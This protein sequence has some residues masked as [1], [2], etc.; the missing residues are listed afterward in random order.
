MGTWG[1]REE[2]EEKEEEEEEEEGKVIS[3]ETK[4]KC[5]AKHIAGHITRIA[6]ESF[7]VRQFSVYRSGAESRKKSLGRQTDRQTNRQAD[8]QT[9][10]CADKHMCFLEK[11]AKKNEIS[12]ATAT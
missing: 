12:T 11:R 7:L 2:E 8:R 10:R 9:G 5:N 4:P 3:K 6:H 1:R